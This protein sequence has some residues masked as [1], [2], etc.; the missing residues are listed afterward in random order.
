MA[1]I[2]P[3]LI[4]AMVC[5]I[6]FTVAGGFSSQIQLG[7]DKI[8]SAVLLD[9]TNCSVIG[10]LT[11]ISEQMAHTKL[12]T[13]LIGTANNYVQQCYSTNS[14][15]L[16]DCNYFVSQRLPGFIDKTA[17][18]PF[19]SSLCR[20][21][22]NNLALDTGFIDTDAHLGL[23]A[24]PE[25]R[26]FIRHRLHCAPLLTEGHVSVNG[27]YTQYD[28]GS[29][30]GETGDAESGYSPGLLNHTHEVE[31]LDNQY[32]RMDGSIPIEQTYMLRLVAFWCSL[33]S[34]ITSTSI[35]SEHNIPA[36]RHP[37]L[38]TA[39]HFLFC[40]PFSKR[41]CTYRPLFADTINGTPG[42]GPSS[43]FIPTAEL[44]RTDADVF[45]V[46]LSG[47]GVFFSEP[48]NDE[49]YRANEPFGVISSTIGEETPAIYRTSE[50]AS[51]LGCASQWQFCNTNTSACGPTASYHDAVSGA[52]Q[53]F[54]M[55]KDESTENTSPASDR[56]EWLVASMG[57]HYNT[58][59]GIL[60]NLQDSAL[61]S[62]QSLSQGYQ[63]PLPDNQWQLDVTNWFSIYLVW[64][65]SNLLQTAAGMMESEAGVNAVKP[66]TE[67]AST[68]CSNQV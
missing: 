66:V 25:E 59:S 37:I 11:S 33:S 35:H 20:S 48:L 31:N 57:I 6:G 3:A 12:T 23:N 17:P 39:P 49:W 43:A 63:G 40:Y 52:A 27:N 56:L 26:L 7:S 28:Y 47:H 58:E 50:P 4:L 61:L 2:A 16:T 5:T 34:S 10:N 67:A 13:R 44:E 54:G 15:G 46:F 8:G 51:P 24:P 62:K 19:D 18:C 41:H 36:R 53:A 45:L 60:L 68:L 1:R 64:I 21:N 30:W 29:Q 14:A 55:N 22:S 42:A 65:Q 38:N 32:A 9:G